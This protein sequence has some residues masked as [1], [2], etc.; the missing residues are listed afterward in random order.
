MPPLVVRGT[1]I[2]ELPRGS[3]ALGIVPQATFAEHQIDVAEND[4]VVVY[5]D[6]ITEAMNESGEFFGDDRLRSILQRQAG[7]SAEK[8]GA[9]LLAAVEAF[10]GGART[11]DDVS[12]VVAR[13][14]Q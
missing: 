5:S 1:S 13:R 10:V 12:I 7:V 14:T 9:A 8:I 3:M 11:H 2:E 4:C 6:G